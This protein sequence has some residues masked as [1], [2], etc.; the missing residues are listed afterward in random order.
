MTISIALLLNF[1][2]YCS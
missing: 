1:S 2:N